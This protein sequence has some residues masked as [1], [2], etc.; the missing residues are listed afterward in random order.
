MVYTIEKGKYMSKR[1]KLLKRLLSVPSDFTY[2]E[3]IRMIRR[4]RR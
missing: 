2:E 1:D 3:V 4:K